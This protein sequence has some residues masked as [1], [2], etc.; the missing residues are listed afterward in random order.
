MMNS[1]LYVNGRMIDGRGGRCDKGW[2]L[3]RGHEIAAAGMH[4]EPV[5]PEA[6]A[7]GVVAKDIAGCTLLPGLIDAHVH[8]TADG[9]PDLARQMTQD[10]PAIAALRMA[11]HALL[12]LQAGFTTVRDLGGIG[13]VN[14]HVRDAIRSGMIPGC[15]VLCA[16]HVICMTGGHGYFMGLE[17]D[18]PDAVRKS[19]RQELKAGADLA[20]FIST[21]GVLTRGVDPSC[22]QLNEDE[23]NAGVEEAHKTGKKTATHAQGTR[24]IELAV[25][26]GIDSIEHGYY[27]TPEL[28]ELMLK[29]GTFLV[30]TITSLTN[31]IGPGE[32]AGIPAWAVEKAKRV[33]E[34][35]WAS[36]AMARKAGVKIAM[37]TDAG[38]PFNRHGRNAEELEEMVKAGFSPMETIVAATGRAAELLGLEATVGTL[39]PGKRA[40]LLVVRGDPLADISLLR[41]AES[42]REIVQAGTPVL[43][44][45]A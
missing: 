21:G 13:H 12:S 41:R 32:S 37:G 28:I 15:S 10:T 14:L 35:A 36:H 19:V 25:K 18:G 29:K 26:A 11:G 20:K 44:P 38:T 23:I 9:S 8:L 17:S 42:F 24:G 45:G 40:D 33:M 27:L 4:G 39:E 3:V 31:I 5:P 2:L 16:G 34:S 22:Y 1:V 30:L 6:H 7:P 43:I